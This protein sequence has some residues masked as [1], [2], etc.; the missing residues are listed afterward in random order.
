MMKRQS[1]YSHIGQIYN[2]MNN[3]FA[4]ATQGLNEA[5]LSLYEEQFTSIMKEAKQTMKADKFEPFQA[6][7]SAR[8]NRMKKNIPT[9]EIKP[10]ISPIQPMNSP[11]EPIAFQS[12]NSPS[13][14]L[15]T[16]QD[17]KDKEIERL[18]QIIINQQVI[19]DNLM[20]MN[21]LKT[22]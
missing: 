5:N 17:D 10:Q 14:G 4:E 8:W 1:N 20:K 2:K 12:Q 6:S 7:N 15:K 16:V 3:L 22:N 9:T 18:K 11:A 21:G 19:I 13:N